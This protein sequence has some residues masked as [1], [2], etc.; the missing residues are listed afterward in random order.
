MED[1]ELLLKLAKEHDKRKVKMP[2]D[3]G[4]TFM[5]LIHVKNLYTDSQF[6]LHPSVIPALESWIQWTKKEPKTYYAFIYCGDKW[7]YVSKEQ[8]KKMTK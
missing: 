6:L 2:Y 8:I 7:Q 1:Y 5:F 3:A 4:K